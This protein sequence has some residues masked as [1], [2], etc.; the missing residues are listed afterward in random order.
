MSANT[1]GIFVSTATNRHNNSLHTMWWLCF[2]Y[3]ISYC[4][5]STGKCFNTCFLSEFNMNKYFKT[6]LSTEKIHRTFKGD[7]FSQHNHDSAHILW[8]RTKLSLPH[9]CRSF[10]LMVDSLMKSQFAT[11]VLLHCVNDM[12]KWLKTEQVYSWTQLGNSRTQ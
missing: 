6:G 2:E 9:L 5:M 11:V 10:L 1:D 3:L 7:H 8:W 4:L 12:N